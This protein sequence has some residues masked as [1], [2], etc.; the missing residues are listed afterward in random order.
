MADEWSA[1]DVDSL[2]AAS[3]APDPDALHAAPPV[4]PPPLDAPPAVAPLA[5]AAPE[6]SPSPDGDDDDV[7]VAVAFAGEACEELGGVVTD[8]EAATPAANAKRGRVA[9]F[10]WPHPTRVTA[11][12][13]V[14]RLAQGKLVPADLTRA[15]VLAQLRNAL[16][17]VRVDK[18]ICAQEPHK[19][20]DPATH[21]RYLHYHCTV[22]TTG[23][24]AHNRVREDLR[25]AG[26]HGWF[27]FPQSWAAAVR[28]VTRPSKHKDFHDLDASPLC[29]GFSTYT[30]GREGAWAAEDGEK[31]KKA[32]R[33]KRMTVGEFADL[34]V[35]CNLETTDDVNALVKRR[36]VDHGDGRLAEFVLS[37]ADLN[38][39]LR[40][41]WAV[42]TAGTARRVA[43]AGLVHKTAYKF[44]RGHFSLPP[45]VAAAV[46]T[47]NPRETT[48]VIGGKAKCGKTALAQALLLE[49]SPVG[50]W[51]TKSLDNLKDVPFRADG[52]DALF[53][54]EIHLCDMSPDQCKNL[55]DLEEASA[56]KC[57]F[58]NAVIPAGTTRAITTQARTPS[59]FLP[60]G[61]AGDDLDAA[62][63]R[64]HFVSVTSDLRK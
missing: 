7:P 3:V 18:A 59:A 55:L 47:W 11:P 49:A 4:D 27:T 43:P 8:D 35:D 36:K 46:N 60:R 39:D 25:R 38:A 17:D 62:L 50:F 58:R 20:R 34:V 33:Q 9:T 56:V 61:M 12:T 41:A 13:K 23:T 42:W 1:A 53:L 26:L 45:D 64:L 30:V 40:K 28:Y 16:G 2:I 22:H 5:A 15:E 54:D 32:T 51:M 24:F 52:S 6:D 29:D 48:L 44:A 21:A 37:R 63:R 14:G 10:T 31:E 19:R 57:R